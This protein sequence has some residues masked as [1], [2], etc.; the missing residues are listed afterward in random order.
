[1]IQDMQIQNGKDL[2]VYATEAPRAANVLSVQLSALEYAEDFGIDLKF[3]LE[4][5]FS[6]QPESFKAYCVQRLLQHGVNVAKTVDVV[7]TFHTAII[8]G[9]GSSETKGGTP[10]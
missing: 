8:F 1:M 4:S 9:I 5:E 10:S 6:I 7:N 2:L 3:F